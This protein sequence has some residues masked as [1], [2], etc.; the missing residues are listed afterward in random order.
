M[1]FLGWKIKNSVFYLITRKILTKIFHR[2]FSHSTHCHAQ[3][4][5]RHRCI[6]HSKN[7][8]QLPLHDL[9]SFYFLTRKN[10]TK[11]LGKKDNRMRNSQKMHI[12]MW[13]DLFFG[14]QGLR[15]CNAHLSFVDVFSFFLVFIFT[16]C[17]DP[18]SVVI[19]DLRNKEDFFERRGNWGVKMGKKYKFDLKFHHFLAWFQLWMK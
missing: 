2:L 11:F 1:I 14:V 12:A 9:L 4:N 17:E 19:W 7:S 18:F 16:H 8:Q 6:I 3:K 5:H 10:N 13:M 15:S